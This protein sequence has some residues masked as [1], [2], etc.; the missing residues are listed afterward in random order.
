[1]LIEKLKV[2]YE[3]QEDL[4]VNPNIHPMAKKAK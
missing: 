3:D 1:M 2:T 4:N